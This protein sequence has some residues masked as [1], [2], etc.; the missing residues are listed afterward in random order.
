MRDYP[1]AVRGIGMSK[2]LEV[3]TVSTD[4]VL[5]S[6]LT[7]VVPLLLPLWVYFPH[8]LFNVIPS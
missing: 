6:R 1:G 3:V 2:S 8:N 5:M 7:A 4:D